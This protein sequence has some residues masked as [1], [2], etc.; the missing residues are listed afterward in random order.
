MNHPFA[1]ICFVFCTAADNA[2]L[3]HACY[4]FKDDFKGHFASDRACRFIIPP[5][6]L[7]DTEPLI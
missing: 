2:F 5:T 4:D 3:L 1:L 7:R 6:F